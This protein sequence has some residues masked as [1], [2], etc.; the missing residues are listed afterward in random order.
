MYSPQLGRFLSRDPIGFRSGINLYQYVAG[1]PPNLI[2]PTGLDPRQHLTKDDSG[3]WDDGAYFGPGPYSPPV[4]DS[5]SAGFA[6]GYLGGG[7]NAQFGPDALSFIADNLDLSSLLKRALGG[8]ECQQGAQ[9]YEVNLSKG[10]DPKV[11]TK[12]TPVSDP[13]DLTD[14]VG[15]S[16]GVSYKSKCSVFVSGV[17]SSGC[18]NASVYCEVEADVRESYH[19]LGKGLSFLQHPYMIFGHISTFRTQQRRL[20]GCQSSNV[21]GT[22]SSQN[23]PQPG[24]SDGRMPLNYSGPALP[25]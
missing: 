1:S 11:G 14:L 18:C 7:Q 5:A 16:V 12:V 15:S 9:Y 19:F 21:I 25:W 3:N 6:Q 13:L 23:P 22:S 20:C 2:D 24:E 4:V 8:T 17:D 10:F